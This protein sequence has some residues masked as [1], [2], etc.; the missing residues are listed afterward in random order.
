MITDINCYQVHCLF[1][2]ISSFQIL[3]L[4]HN[5]DLFDKFLDLD[6]DPKLNGLLLMPHLASQ[7]KFHQKNL[8][9]TSSVI[10]K[11]HTIASILHW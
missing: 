6:C 4:L 11:F 3:S 8:L 5:G 1:V 7:I 9:T 10:S 2:Y